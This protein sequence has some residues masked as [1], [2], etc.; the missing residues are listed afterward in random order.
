V[1]HTGTPHTYLPFRPPHERRYCLAF[2]EE[3]TLPWQ[4]EPKE[5]V[6]NMKK[7]LFVEECAIS[8]DGCDAQLPSDEACSTAHCLAT[9][10]EWDC[11]PEL[12]GLWGCVLDAQDG[13]LVDYDACIRE[14]SE[15]Y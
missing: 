4:W 15:E 9:Y 10:E 14:L 8:G 2:L 11:S 13:T 7:K 1:S 5:H 6:T 3:G 12:H